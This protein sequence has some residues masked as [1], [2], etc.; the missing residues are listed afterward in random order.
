MT[1]KIAPSEWGFT[2]T[3]DGFPVAHSH[4][5]QLLE[6][7]LSDRPTDE[8]PDMP[9]FAK[10]SYRTRARSTGAATA[11]GRTTDNGWAAMCVSHGTMVTADAG[12]AAEKLTSKPEEWCGECGRIK[13][14]E[15]PKVAKNAELD[16][17]L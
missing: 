17:L 1:T 8:E 3:M 7:Y 16:D 11:S 5:K 9:S 12:M 14:G 4:D 13:A 2:A 15:L 10:I 6:D